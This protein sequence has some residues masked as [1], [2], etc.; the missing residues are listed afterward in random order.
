MA[1]GG[2]RDLA[3]AVKDAAAISSRVHLPAPGGLAVASWCP[4]GLAA[5]QRPPSATTRASELDGIPPVMRARRR[6]NQLRGVAPQV[7][8][9]REVRR[10]WRGW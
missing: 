9:G 2:A 4:G 8:E 10:R 6:A 7:A 1:S 5:V 3:V